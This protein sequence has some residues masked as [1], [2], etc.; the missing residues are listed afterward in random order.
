MPGFKT[1]LDYKTENRGLKFKTKNRGFW[2]VF[3][4]YSLKPSVEI[5][6][7][8]PVWTTLLKTGEKNARFLASH[9]VWFSP[10]WSHTIAQ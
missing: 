4:K 8:K 3:L 9:F 2:L 5:P 7:L 6:V 10:N 1:L